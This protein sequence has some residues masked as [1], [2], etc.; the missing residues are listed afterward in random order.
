MS[1]YL[2]DSISIIIPENAV[3]TRS[4]I[5]TRDACRLWNEIN[6]DKPYIGLWGNKSIILELDAVSDRYLVMYLNFNWYE[7]AKLSNH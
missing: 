1:G 6:R 3:T 7:T 2:Y 5:K 4:D